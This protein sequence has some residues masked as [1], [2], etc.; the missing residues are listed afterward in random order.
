MKTRGIFIK[1][2][3]YTIISMV[4][5]VFIT[6]VLYSQQFISFYG[7]TRHQ[8]VS[9]SFRPLVDRLEGKS[10]SDFPRIA[11]SFYESN[12]SFE[13]Y[14]EDVKNGGVIY[15]TPHADT[16]GS[17]TLE[18]ALSKDYVVRAR[19]DMGLTALHGDLI[20]L[21]LGAF[22]AM[23]ALC[24]I[25]A[26]VFARQMTRPIKTLADAA[27]KM[28]NL[29]AVPPLPERRD[30]LGT[31]GRD[32]YSM[33]SKLKETI[34]KLEEE[35]LRE[36]ELEETQAFFFSAASHELKT[37]ITATSVLLEGMLENV[38]DYKDHPKYLRE[39]VKMM[40]A[41]SKVISEILEIVNL[42]NG[43][44]VPFPEKLDVRRTFADMLPDFQIM[45]EAN[46]QRIVTDI[47]DGQIC[48]ADPKMLRKA[49]SNILLNAVQNTPKGGEIRI[50]SEPA[51]GQYR[52]CVLNTGV[53]IDEAILPKLFDP[54]YRMDKARS[55]KNGRSGL[56]L[57]IVRKTLESM[58]MN[59][60]LEN[61]ADGVLFWMDLLK[62]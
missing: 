39:C 30:E 55:R 24:V 6:V 26:F 48:F 62:A 16:S 1:V 58:N 36:H 41:Q 11:Q 5:L 40:D 57:T 14:I 28:A 45:C 56:G 18:V 27:N 54:F 31:L 15:A 8:Q 7:L 12:Q 49:L 50:W 22:I 61:A 21:A 42:S 9:E 2:F 34:S 43:K 33:Y 53:R 13:F 46:S 47:P 3:I 35:I 52:L 44:I 37:P 32:V 59:F 23:I 17:S 38:G 19:S 10:E 4:L 29:E 60:A 25:C 51:S 20:K